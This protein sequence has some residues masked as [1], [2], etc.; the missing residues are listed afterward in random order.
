MHGIGRRVTPLAVLSLTL[1]LQLAT[2]AEPALAQDTSSIV[3]VLL[4]QSYLQA[5]EDLQASAA[6]VNFYNEQKKALRSELSRLRGMLNGTSDPA[7]RA[8]LELDIK[9]VEEELQ[10][11]GD[12]AQLANVDLQRA[13]QQQQQ[14]MQ[15]M[16]SI[17]KSL[18]DTAMS[19]IRK[20]G[21]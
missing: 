8:E 13:L 4:R 20:I 17:S 16:S 15:I 14:L 2:T 3:L 21:G 11:V 19:T 10:T 5:T 1:V 12:D 6:R 9:D 18:H 7:A